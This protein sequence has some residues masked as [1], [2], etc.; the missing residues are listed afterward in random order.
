MQEFLDNIRSIMA[1]GGW[2]MYPLLGMSLLSLTLS[3]ERITFWLRMHA[4]RR[5]NRL[6]RVSA[7]LRRGDLSEAK[8][9]AGVDSSFYGRFTSLMLED[10][11]SGPH[12]TATAAAAQEHAEAIRPAIER[13]SV[14]LSTIVTAAP[15]L[16]ILGTVTGIIQSFHLFG[17]QETVTDPAS[18]AGGIAEALYT[19]AFGLIVALLTLF[20][21]VSFRAQADRAFGRIEALAAAFVEAGAM[22]GSASPGDRVKPDETTPRLPVQ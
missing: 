5:I 19:T 14:I 10:F 15:M 22:N 1:I 16:G 21:Y 13:F 4:R 7:R 6:G 20:P 8:A 11:E 17:G 2:V 18:V 3:F 12:G 9:M